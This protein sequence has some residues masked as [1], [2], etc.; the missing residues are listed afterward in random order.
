MEKL[1]LWF[2]AVRAPFFVASLIPVLVGAAVGGRMG[3]FKISS[4][5]FAL[6]IV[7]FNHAGS[8]LLNDFF[9]S[10][11]SDPINKTPTPFSGGSRMIQQNL[12]PKKTF[13]RVA[14]VFFGLSISLTGILSLNYH[15]FMIFG[16]GVGGVILGVSYSATHIFGMGKGWGEIA[17]GAA[18][19]P[20]SVLGSFLLQT[21]FFAWE[22]LLAGVP[23][24]FLIMGVLILNEFPDLEADRAVGKRNW[25]VRVG[26][27]V[28]GV[29]IYLTIISLAY[30]TVLAGVFL[31]FFPARVLFSYSTIPLAVWV[32]LKTWQ[33]KEKVPEIIP[34]LAG[35]IGL[36]F[37]TGLLICLGIW[38][39]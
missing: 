17:V 7:I 26:G 29:G 11:G 32:G 5:L 13:L 6:V 34:A 33:Y 12:L 36:H 22:A 16:L 2:K 31:K 15:N 3:Y 24:G 20:L 39:K 8:N 30:V 28:K 21:N 35:N 38:W 10:E 18:F 25:I 37:I 19:G 1:L 9:D 27:G 4:L 14:L 23:V